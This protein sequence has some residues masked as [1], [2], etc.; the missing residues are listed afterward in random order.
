ML[1]LV[2]GG[3]FVH[4]NHFYA[5]PSKTGHP[6]KKECPVTC[7][8]VPDMVFRMPVTIFRVPFA[9]FRVPFAIFHAL[10]AVFRVPETGYHAPIA[11]I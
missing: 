4:Y 11:F 3:N 5:P 10:G 2:I 9:V 1:G 7:F 6:K 8:R